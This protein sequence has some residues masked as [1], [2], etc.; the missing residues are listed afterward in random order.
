M[1]ILKIAAVGGGQLA[2]MLGQAAKGLGHTFRSASAPESCAF[3][4]CE[5]FTEPINEDNL[6]SF[7][8]DVDV[9]TFESEHE[10]L[11]VSA[12]IEK[13]GIPI[14]PSPHFV[15]I[16][17]DRNLEKTHLQDLGI[18]TAPFLLIDTDHD[19]ASLDQYLA[20]IVSTQ[21]LS[22]SGIVIKTRHGGYDGKGQWV[23]KT[24]QN[25]DFA[26]VALEILPATKNPGCI[27]EGLVDFSIECSI[28]ATRSIDGKI[29][30]WPLTEN[31]HV[32]SI[33]RRSVSPITGI[34]NLSELENQ[35]QAIA[36]NLCEK[37]NYVG[38]IAIE[39]FVTKTGLIVNEIAPRV[40][41]SG[42]WT[43]EGSK[44]S[45]FEQHIRA[46][47]G[48][49]LGSTESSGTSVMINLVGIDVNKEAL[50]NIDGVYLHWYGK[51]V[52]PNRKVGHITIVADT[53]QECEKLERQVNQILTT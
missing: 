43:I 35:A 2:Q 30:T 47:T 40:H 48:M 16:A 50:S 8:S 36:I 31:E 46:V 28:I 22:A 29:K 51:E 49:E 21:V 45:Q 42:H 17:G 4:D 25:T 5:P 44:T 9:F 7:L 14:Y 20:N 37:S 1:T 6:K 34:A 3:S 11:E 53:A 39:C 15:E 26:K 12:N 32:D 24:G 18:P 10:G 19:A 27:V 52:R 13:L 38:T 23:I 33:L 41:N